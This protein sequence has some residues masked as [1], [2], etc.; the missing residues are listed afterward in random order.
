MEFQETSFGS[1][2]I[3]GKNYDH[4]VVIF[5]GGIERRE[6]SISKRKHGTRHKFTKEEMKNYIQGKSDQIKLLVVGTG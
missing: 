4:D 5:S 2:K 6:K 3:D 1:I